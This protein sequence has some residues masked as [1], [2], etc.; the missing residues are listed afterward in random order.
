MAKGDGALVGLVHLLTVVHWKLPGEKTVGSDGTHCV[1]PLAILHANE[2]FV[3]E[4]ADHAPSTDLDRD[5]ISR[6][7]DMLKHLTHVVTTH[8]APNALDLVAHLQLGGG[9]HVRFNR[10]H[11]HTTLPHVNI[12]AQR[13]ALLLAR[14]LD[15]EALDIVLL[16]LSRWLLHLIHNAR[17]ICRLGHHLVVSPSLHLELRPQL[18]NRTLRCLELHS[19]F[20]HLS[21][22]QLEGLISF[23]MST[24]DSLP[25]LLVE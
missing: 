15:R 5:H 17:R 2:H 23:R 14:H 16:L 4:H 24:A 9:R 1:L 19:E 12:D 22:C 8:Q 20:R 13:A 25:H 11:S 10:S 18:L 7:N 21:V 6:L 3:T